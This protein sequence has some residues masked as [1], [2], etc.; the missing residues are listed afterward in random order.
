MAVEFLRRAPDPELSVVVP[1][2]PG[3]DRT[4]LEA[5][6][7]EQDVDAPY[8]ALLVVDGSVDRC[9][10]RNIGLELARADVV[11]FTDD[12]CLPP[13]DWLRSILA[14]FR[15]DPELVLLEGAVYGGS[16]YRGERHYVG[17]NLAVD[18]TTAI[19]VGGF[20]SAYAAWAED[21]EFGWRMERDAPGTCRYADGV[22]M[23][24]PAVP[25]TPVDPA[26]ERRLR[27]EYPDRYDAVIRSSWWKRLRRWARAR[28]LLH[29]VLSLLA[30]RRA[31]RPDAGPARGGPTDHPGR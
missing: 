26:T 23:C 27:Q 9:A 11:A 3:R 2:L 16:R 14:V 12:D 25:R 15:R 6:L 31:R 7:V 29:P 21:T 17:C 5:R 20:R 19:G 10:A 18:R 8:E 13:R 1:T 22:R 24:H 4:R 30:S 28:G